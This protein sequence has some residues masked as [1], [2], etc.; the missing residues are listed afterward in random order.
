MRG[1]ILLTALVALAGCLPPP[2]PQSEADSRV[3]ELTPGM[4]FAEVAAIQGEAT[5]TTTIQ[6]VTCVAYLY[7]RTTAPFYVHAK[8]QGGALV[9]ATDG[10]NVSC[11]A[12]A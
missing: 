12:P 9:S 8:F 6:G 7:D 3:D 11:D 1:P 5:D 10:H 4:S 2:P